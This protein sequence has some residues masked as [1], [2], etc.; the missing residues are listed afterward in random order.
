MSHKRY[1]IS[2][3]VTTLIIYSSIFLFN[4]IVDPFNTNK[5]F[6]FGFDKP[7]IAVEGINNRIYKMQAF[8]KK[9]TENILLGDSRIRNLNQEL[10]EKVSNEKY[11][12]LGY[13][14][15]TLYEVIDTFWFATQ[16]T[17]LKNVYIGINFNLYSYNNKRNLI[18]EASKLIKMEYLSYLCFYV[19]KLSVQNII[20]K[21]TKINPTDDKPKMSKADFWEK[22]LDLD[23]R[24]FYNN[25]KY[26]NNLL[27]ELIKI[28]DYCDKND[29]NLIFIIPPTHVD[30]QNEVSTYSLENEYV[31]YKNDLKSI[32]KTI[33]FDYPNKWT[34]NYDLFLDPYHADKQIKN[35]FIRDIFSND[36]MLMGREL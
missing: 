10:I 35:I 8:T 3:I 33:D 24:G 12:N 34:K 5:L 18:P 36:S 21:F 13:G 27:N 25:Y 9:P 1:S 17:K 29:I 26:P 31:K 32:T 4:F 16:K 2:I 22:Q 6:N 15:A 19:T 23:T 20:Y 30:L 7:L 11:F 14:G 28:K